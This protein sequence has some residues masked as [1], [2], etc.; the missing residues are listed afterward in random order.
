MKRL[1]FNPRTGSILKHLQGNFKKL[2][3]IIPKINICLIG[4]KAE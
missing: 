3:Y 2:I 4:D 1:K